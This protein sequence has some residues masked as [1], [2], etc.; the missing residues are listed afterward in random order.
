M[1][2]PDNVA[3]LLVSPRTLSLRRNLHRVVAMSP[4]N[5]AISAHRYDEVTTL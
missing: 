3:R 2:L 4:Q 5:G 1:I